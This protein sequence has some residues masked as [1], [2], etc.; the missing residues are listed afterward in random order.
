MTRDYK[1]GLGALS[2]LT[3]RVADTSGLEPLLPA[4]SLQGRAA[5]L[6]SRL[7]ARADI[8]LLVLDAREGVV[9]ADAELARWLRRHVDASRVMV[10]ANK[11]EGRAAQAG[12]SPAPPPPSPF[13]PSS[14]GRL[15]R[16][17]RCAPPA[18][19]RRPS[20]WRP[21]GALLLLP[22]SCCPLLA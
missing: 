10:V 12:A 4:A 16:C 8:A 15:R 22:R 3:F 7:V 14:R 1:E 5:A 6:T 11:A 21:P 17:A 18:P 19:S 2:D 20:S 9:P 13:S